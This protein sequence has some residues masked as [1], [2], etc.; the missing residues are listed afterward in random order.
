MTAAA[1]A[2]SAGGG[3]AVSAA[4]LCVCR[5]RGGYPDEHLTGFVFVKRFSFTSRSDGDGM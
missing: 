4:D 3:D 2:T 5:E 1:A